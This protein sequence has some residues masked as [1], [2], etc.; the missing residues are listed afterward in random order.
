MGFEGSEDKKELI[1]FTIFC[2]LICTIWCVYYAVRVAPELADPDP[3]FRMNRVTDLYEGG[4][5]Y[6]TI[7]FR[8]NAPYG[9]TLHWT[10]PFD[11]LLLAGALPATIFVD[12]RTALFW[13]GVIISPV[14]LVAMLLTMLWAARPLLSRQGPFL[15]GILLFFQVG[16]MGYCSPGR[17]DQHSLSALLFVVLFGF[18]LRLVSWPANRWLCCIAGVIG[19][20]SIWAGMDLALV[21]FAIAAILGLLWIWENGDFARKSAYYSIWLFVA[22]GISLLAERPL[23]NLAAKEF[24][25][26]SI[27]HW[28]VCGF[29]AG[30]WIIVGLIS[31]FSQVLGRRTVRLIFAAAGAGLIAICVLFLFPKMS[32]SVALSFLFPRFL[33]GQVSDVDPRVITVWYEKISELQHIFSRGAPIGMSVQ[34]AGTVLVSAGI[35]AYLLW[36]RGCRNKRGW[37]YV[38]V[39]LL[40]Y[41]P[42]SIYRIRWTP[43]AQILLMLP[44]AELMDRAL[45]RIEGQ[46]PGVMRVLKN[47]S[48]VAAF[49]ATFLVLGLAAALAIEDKQDKDVS[50]VKICRYLET[51]EKWQGKSV[52]ILTDTNFGPEIL[53]RTR[54]ETIGSPN[55]R[56]YRGI[57][58]T[59]DIMTAATDDAAHELIE[60]RG[61][62]LIL[63]CFNSRE[64]GDSSKAAGGTKFYQRLFHGE[65]PNWLKEVELPT[66]LSASF[67]LFEIK[68]D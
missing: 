5:W 58:D 52:R 54:H 23:N 45:K 66:E 28:S 7:F 29:L 8:S 64:F 25:R 43:Y 37:G 15:V 39:L 42:L 36:S 1:R 24:D 12:F 14:L 44:M 55:Q 53:Y 35:L 31:R 34:F 57:L 4:G 3:F 9:E 63:L 16:V 48:V 10:R 32:Q 47:V 40:I 51:C 59:Y 65:Y 62:E 13:W 19:G 56:N 49:S 30:F 6:Q 38:L 33:G 61:I 22:V 18:G 68:R 46:K 11:V 17:G 60:Q 41:I 67:K 21:V 27:V 20:L 26:L 2:I 50:I